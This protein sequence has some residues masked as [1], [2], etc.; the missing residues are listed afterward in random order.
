LR[1]TQTTV[2][3][4]LPRQPMHM[5]TVTQFLHDNL[6]PPWCAASSERCLLLWFHFLSNI[7]IIRAFS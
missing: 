7:V 1:D 3:E 6:C 5:E 2:V 4:T